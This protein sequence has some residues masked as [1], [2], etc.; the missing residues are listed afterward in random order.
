MK[1][2]L[3]SCKMFSF[4]DVSY[5]K[6]TTKKKQNK[7]RKETLESSQYLLEII[8]NFTYNK[9]ETKKVYGELPLSENGSSIL[10]KILKI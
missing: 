10:H 2:V 4:W 9:F 6:T 8:F 5:E 3:R 7:K 1:F